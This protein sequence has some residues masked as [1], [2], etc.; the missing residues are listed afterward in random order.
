MPNTERIRRFR[1]AWFLTVFLSTAIG[2]GVSAQSVSFPGAKSETESP[3]RRY[4]IRNSDSLTENPAHTLSLVEAKS[5]SAI[6][7]Y[8]YA[9]SADVLWSPAS[10]A[11]VINDYEGSDSTR[12]VLYAVPWTG[13][14]ADLLEE[15]THFLRRRH[16]EKLVLKN[17]HVYFTVRRW[18]NPHELLCQLEAY[19]GA[20][21]HG[22]GFNGYYVYRIGEGFR[23]YNPKDQVN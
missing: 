16:E 18:I 21:P 12:P 2:S 14:K 10:D 22:S 5:G 20:S 23:L 15:F 7:I 9:R 11:F 6:K 19:G 3:D 4:V 1:A 13:T 17:D 8:Q